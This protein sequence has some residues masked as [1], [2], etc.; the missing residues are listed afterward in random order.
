MCTKQFRRKKPEELSKK[1]F[2]LLDTAH[3]CIAHVMKAALATLGWK[4]VNCLTYSSDIVPTCFHFYG[5]LKVC[6]GGQKVQTDDEPKQCIWPAERMCNLKRIQNS[7]NLMFTLLLTL[8][9]I[10]GA[11]FDSWCSVMRVVSSLRYKLWGLQ[12]IEHRRS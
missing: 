8:C 10:R 7:R 4:I 12:H 2:C 1:K 5:P 3:P 6:L 9:S 11:V